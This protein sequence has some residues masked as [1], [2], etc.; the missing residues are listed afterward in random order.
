MALSLRLLA[1]ASLLAAVALAATASVGVR[2]ARDGA[3]EAGAETTSARTAGSSEAGAAERAASR[4]RS[5]ARGAAASTEKRRAEGASGTVGGASG[6]RGRATSSRPLL[7]RVRAG[8]S[9]PVRSRPGG[10]VIA[11][12][13]ARTEFD[14]PQVLGAVRTSGRW[15]GVASTARTDGELGWIDGR[16]SALRPAPAMVS[17]RADLSRRRVELRRGDRVVARVAVAVGRPSSSTPTGRFTVTDKLDGRRL[18]PYYGC[19]VLALSG[20]QPNLPAGWTGGDRLAIHG[21]NDPG[22]IGQASSAGCL[23]TGDAAL[24]KLMR[25]VPLG[26]PVEI[27]D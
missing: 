27:R 14:S 7:V 25:R 20:T 24:R 11:R 18:S 23:R 3:S 2:D 21:T 12:L 6:E 22:S 13:D 5:P 1:V 4:M 9:I 19:C 26:T 10:R 8:R 16:S 17:L 15:L